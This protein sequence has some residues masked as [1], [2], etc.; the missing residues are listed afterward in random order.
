MEGCIVHGGINFSKQFIGKALLAS[1]SLKVEVTPQF[2]IH[3]GALI[4]LRGSFEDRR[5]C[6]FR[7]ALEVLLEGGVLSLL[8][9]I[10]AICSRCAMFCCLSDF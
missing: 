1:N 4:V 8:R 6:S 3:Y 2:A 5:L 9:D 7:E 10:K